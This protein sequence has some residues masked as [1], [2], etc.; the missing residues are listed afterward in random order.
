MKL[1]THPMSSNARKVVIA[2][3]LLDI[4]VDLE[5]VD[6]TK[7][8]QR[9]PEYLAINPNGK[10]PVLDDAGFVLWES[11]AILQYL[12]ARRPGNALFPEEARAR[13]DVARWQFWSL[14]HWLPAVQILVFERMFKPMLQMGE[15]DPV[16]IG[17][18]EERFHRFAGVLDGCLRGREYL[19]GNALTFAD[20]SVAVHLMYAQGAQ[21]PLENYP[22]IR[23]WFLQI[24]ALP[25]WKKTA[26]P[27]A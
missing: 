26:P 23:R 13:A 4:A 2:A 16:E 22:Q 5:L 21:L 1:Y 3:Q 25:A 9:R 20:I 15:P 17:K 11:D 18:G 24:Q 6:L 10:V 7:G 14:A 19:V 12:A 8:A 27:A